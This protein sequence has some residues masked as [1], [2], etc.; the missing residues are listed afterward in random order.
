MS[1]KHDREE[2]MG[3]SWASV[4]FGWLAALGATLIL[5]G[6]VGV[7]VAA[8]F[9]ALGFGSGA[10]GGISGLMGLLITFFLGFLVGGYAAGRM[11]S[12]S[13]A[14]HGLLVAF[15]ALV[16]AIVL[17]LLGGAVGI[18]LLN[19]P[20]VMMPNVPTNLPSDVPDLGAI[21][22]VWGILALLCP[23]IGDAIGSAWDAN[24]GRQRPS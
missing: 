20:G 4:V 17:A 21:L 12:R 23:F 6:I 15:L 3:T 22:S 1:D 13:G 10:E 5:S 7:V 16:V 18:N 9:A 8:I 14:K 24:T 2:G 11:A 19:I